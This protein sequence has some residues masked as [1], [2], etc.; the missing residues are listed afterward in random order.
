MILPYPQTFIQELL[1]GRDDQ[2]RVKTQQR[3]V[4]ATLPEDARRAFHYMSMLDRMKDGESSLLM[5]FD[6]RIK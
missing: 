1:S 3:A 5:P 6:I 4:L 2:T